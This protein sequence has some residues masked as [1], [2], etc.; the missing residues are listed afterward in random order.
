MGLYICARQSS[1]EV[2]NESQRTGPILHTLEGISPAMA[3]GG[4]YPRRMCQGGSSHSSKASR[5]IIQ[6]LQI[7]NGNCNK[8]KELKTIRHPLKSTSSARVPGEVCHPLIYQGGRS[9]SPK[10]FR[11]VQNKLQVKET[12]SLGSQE[13]IRILHPHKGI[14]SAR[15]QGE[16]CRPLM[17]Q[18]GCSH[19]PRYSKIS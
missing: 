19:S 15:V 13:I 9:H 10:A 17:Y 11:I 12:R 18:G 14:G 1:S 4:G 5:I 2:I 8:S 3:Q 7:G 6:K 16:S